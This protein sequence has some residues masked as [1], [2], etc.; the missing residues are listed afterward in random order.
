MAINEVEQQDLAGHLED[1][2]G[3]LDLD[4]MGLA[5]NLGSATTKQL[6]EVVE[7]AECLKYGA[8]IEMWGREREHRG[9]DHT[10]LEEPPEGYEGWHNPDIQ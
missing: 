3:E 2:V 10:H 1:A 8:L 7:F 5:H 6:H 4:A 9:L